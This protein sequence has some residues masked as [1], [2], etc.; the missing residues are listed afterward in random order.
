MYINEAVVK[1]EPKNGGAHPFLTRDS[2]L[3]YRLHR[4]EE[5]RARRGVVVSRELRGRVPD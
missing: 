3:E 4:R 5:I 2:R 1:E